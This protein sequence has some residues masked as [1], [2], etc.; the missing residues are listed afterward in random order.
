MRCAVGARQRSRGLL[1]ASVFALREPASTELLALAREQMS[2]CLMQGG[3][4]ALGWYVSEPA[5]NDFPR[6]PVREGE[7]VLVLLGMFGDAALHQAWMAQAPRWWERAPG[8]AAPP[9]V[10][11]LAPTARSALQAS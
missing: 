6:L 1:E 4:Q 7:P 10:L 11:R 2:P 8:L 9:Q 3:A 5:R